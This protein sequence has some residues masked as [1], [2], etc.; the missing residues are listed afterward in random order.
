MLL[1]QDQTYIVRV[2]ISALNAAAAAHE[3]H[4]DLIL[5]DIARPGL[6]GGEVAG[7]IR[8]NP[9]LHSIPIVF[10]TGTATHL[11]L[12]QNDGCI[13][14]PRFPAKPPPPGELT[15]GAAQQLAE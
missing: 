10:L 13:G 7:Q 11:E 2:E 8:A 15:D 5:M 14:G 12:Q 3:F 9:A 4:P 1:E 6:R